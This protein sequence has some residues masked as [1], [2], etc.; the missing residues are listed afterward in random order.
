MAQMQQ[1]FIEFAREY[2]R[3][4][5]HLVKSQKHFIER[6]FMGR[7]PRSLVVFFLIFV[8]SSFSE[9]G[10]LNV[11]ISLPPEPASSLVQGQDEWRYF[12]GTSAPNGGWQTIADEELGP[13]WASG[14]GGFGFAADNPVE[15]SACRTILNDMFNR[16][17]SFYMRRTFHIEEPPQSGQRLLLTVDWDDGFVAYIDGVEVARSNAPGEIG[18][19]PGFNAVATAAHESSLGNIDPQPRRTTDLGNVLKDLRPGPHVLAVMGFNAAI[20]NPDFVLV[21]ELVLTAPEIVVPQNGYFALV[22][23][24]EVVLSGENTIAQSTRVTV[25]GMRAEYHVANGTWRKVCRLKE[26]MNTFSV[27]ALDTR[28][29]TLD[30]KIVRVLSET[31][32]HQAGGVIGIGTTWSGVIRLTNKVTTLPGVSLTL[33]PGTVVLIPEGGGITAGTNSTV[34]ATG[35]PEGP[36]YLVPADGIS[37]W[38]EFAA[39]G[40]NASVWAA[41]VEVI[42]GELASHDGG[43][44]VRPHAGHPSAPRN[45]AA[46]LGFGSQVTLRWE[47]S[48]DNEDKFVVERSVDGE[49]W[50]N[51]SMVEQNGTFLVDL[52]AE[53][54]R[55][56]Y[57]RV[58]AENSLGVSGWSNVAWANTGRWTPMGGTLNR[59]LAWSPDMGKLLVTE[60]LIIPAEVS[61]N[62]SGAVGIWI[63]NEASILAEAG[64]TIEIT[65]G[66]FRAMIARA[67]PGENWGKLSAEGPG[68]VLRMGYVDVSG[69]QITVLSNAVG[70]VEDSY[71][72]DYRNPDGTL[73]TAAIMLS[74]FAAE[75]TVRGCH[76]SEYEEVLFRDGVITVEDSLFEY[77]SGDGL[78]FDG[79]QPGTVLR[80]CTFRHG[81]RAPS[82]IDAVDVGP[83]DLGPSRDVLIEDCLIFDFPTD[84]GVSIG[85][86][87]HPAIGTV[88]RNCLIYGCH[89][90]VQVKDGAFAEVSNCT[91]TGNQW[92]LT[93]YNKLNPALSTGGGHTTNAHNNIIWGNEVNI[94]MWNGGTLSADHSNIE[95]MLWPGEGNINANPE[96]LNTAARDYRLRS[97]SPS[98]Q[99]GREGTALGA[100]YPVGAPMAPSHP[101]I[102]WGRDMVLRFWADNEKDYTLE[103][104][105]SLTAGEWRVVTHTS[106]LALPG[107][108]E[109]SRPRLSNVQFYR[110]TGVPRR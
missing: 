17:T 65:G 28:G 16:Y 57:Y 87:P 48:S 46:L 68:A 109:M 66:P 35:N 106:S 67:V 5:V 43:A 99:S 73:F 40:A 96:F 93:N 1:V 102:E 44:V 36:I 77:S 7:V 41:N 71:I 42:G 45:L 90:G 88:V 105:E 39:I 3:G 104:R 13:E 81:T 11:E 22:K 25:N 100:R 79:A 51:F 53:L 108:I 10:T 12:K 74:S 98:L 55:D 18:A 23:T 49:I 107:I 30:S 37:Q 64:G 20:D 85:D 95:G 89:S 50:E 33:T 24:N 26:G 59:D 60:T 52:T 15:T 92:G 56:Y 32:L 47:D 14:A 75:M 2:D 27:A 91:I 70:V 86:A 61:F 38:E 8:R 82:N 4:A 21:A 103:A 80:R 62:V 110:I 58:R 9:P 63:T 94:S 76:V 72:H 29:Q 83:G 97:G 78:D 84:K 31:S 54:E 19:E 101:R 6:G 34:V 69:G